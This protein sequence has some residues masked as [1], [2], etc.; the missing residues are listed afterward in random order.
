MNRKITTFLM[1]DGDAEEAMNFYTSL[2][3]DSEIKSII[4]YQAEENGREGTVRDAVFYLNGQEFM[5]IDTAYKHDFN[6]T[7][8]IS[9]FVECKSEV[10]IDKLYQ[11][12]TEEGKVFMV[13]GAYDFAEKYAWVQDK[14]GVSWQLVF[15]QKS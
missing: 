10:E 3:D 7:P 13:L 9:F 6:F 2:F 15:N 4:H 8:S 12:F 11:A 14:F 1:F 5:C